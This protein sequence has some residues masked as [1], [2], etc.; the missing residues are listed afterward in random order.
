[1]RSPTHRGRRSHG[2]S[3]APR[4]FRRSM[5]RMALGLRLLGGDLCA[6]V[7]GAAPFAPGH[8]GAVSKLLASASRPGAGATD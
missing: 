3:S 8:G 2:T 7:C 1:M 6:G 5:F 4:C